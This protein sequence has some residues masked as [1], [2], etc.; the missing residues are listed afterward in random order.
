MRGALWCEIGLLGGFFC[1]LV[2]RPGFI[3]EMDRVELEDFEIH[4]IAEGEMCFVS[5]ENYLLSR[6]QP[7][8]ST[9]FVNGAVGGS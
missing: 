7:S 8:V 3:G 1:V 9:M 6:E 2:L 5:G 4:A